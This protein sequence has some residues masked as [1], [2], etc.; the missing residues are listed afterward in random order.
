MKREDVLLLKL[1][2]ECAEV[3]QRA[4]KLLQFGRLEVE[5]GQMFCNARRLRDEVNDLLTVI[6]MLEQENLLL[7]S[8]PEELAVH[9]EE[10]RKK[11]ERYLTYSQQLGVVEAR[12]K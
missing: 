1:A 4:A 8:S 7:I 11:I 5:P 10:K 9:K 12:K 6:E 2:E 3:Q